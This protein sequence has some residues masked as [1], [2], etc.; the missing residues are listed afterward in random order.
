MTGVY[1]VTLDPLRMLVI[2]LAFAFAF[3]S[4]ILIPIAVGMDI[5][6]TILIIIGH[7]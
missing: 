3:I 1:A 6:P 5:M 2:G 4:C 7:Y